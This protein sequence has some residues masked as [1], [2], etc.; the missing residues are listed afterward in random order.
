MKMRSLFTAI[1]ALCFV[2][3]LTLGRM[4][5]TKSDK[6]E[7]TTKSEAKCC[8]KG[9]KA[10]MKNCPHKSGNKSCCDTKKSCKMSKKSG[11]K[12]SETKP[13]KDKE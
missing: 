12:S 7:T 2:F 4:Q 6:K 13:G 10:D 9:S 8:D 11:N 5:D 3:S 1:I